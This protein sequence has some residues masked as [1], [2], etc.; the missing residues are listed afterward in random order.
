MLQTLAIL[1]WEGNPS[2]KMVLFQF[3]S[4]AIAARYDLKSSVFSLGRTTVN[5]S[6]IPPSFE[7]MTDEKDARFSFRHGRDCSGSGSCRSVLLH[8]ESRAR[9]LE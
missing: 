6:W 2:R 1:N 8:G 3:P 7:G 4:K 9:I 5:S